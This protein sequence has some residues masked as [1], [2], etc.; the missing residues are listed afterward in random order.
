MIESKGLS[1]PN[2]F[3]EKDQAVPGHFD[4][5]PT[6]PPVKSKPKPRL[7]GLG[8][9]TIG[10]NFSKITQRAFSV[11]QAEHYTPLQDESD[12]RG[13]LPNRQKTRREGQG[14][15]LVG[16]RVMP[17]LPTS[18]RVNML[19]EEDS[20][21]FDASNGASLNRRGST[22]SDLDEDHHPFDD[23]QYVV[24]PPSVP[25]GPV[26]TPQI[27]R[28]EVDPTELRQTETNGPN[29]PP[30]N[31]L[32]V[33]ET[34][35]YR[36]PSFNLTD[37]AEPSALLSLPDRSFGRSYRSSV[38][39]TYES[40]ESEGVIHQAHHAAVLPASIVSP[41]TDLSLSPS[42]TTYQPVK[43][44]ESFFRR[45]TA[46]GI[47]GLLSG[48]TSSK[49]SSSRMSM[50]IRDPAPL[51][52][53]WPIQSRDEMAA[54]SPAESFTESPRQSDWENDLKPPR[55]LWQVHG[56]G[57]LVSSLISARSMRDMVIVQRETPNT[58][59]EAV[60]EQA[61]GS[62]LASSS[63]SESNIGEDSVLDEANISPQ[64]AVQPV[65][66]APRKLRSISHLQLDSP[67]I[68][69]SPQSAPSTRSEPPIP[70]SGS[71]ISAAI[72]SHRRPVKDMVKSINKRSSR[73]FDSVTL[74]ALSPLSQYSPS[75]SPPSSALGMEDKR[76]RTMYEAVRKSPLTVA[77]PDEGKRSNN[78]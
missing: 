56:K 14:I 63:G 41:S 15:R 8:M 73:V 20:R 44:T 76:P 52:T 22:G 47:S 71:P 6:T 33:D 4:E 72:V 69:S 64:A 31:D 36:I 9:G 16:P 67:S 45:M 42:S 54:I 3:V 12:E 35:Q 17:D 11:P 46:G 48:S 34:G 75:S 30:S 5:S 66:L 68:A 28:A 13:D 23:G 40:S 10:A 77:N 59:T 51:P 49:R 57:V 74:D 50:E 21:I 29:L 26:P 27:S 24:V 38:V 18:P 61:T 1:K 39:S 37:A 19:A 58:E 70:P 53:L 55:G 65:P 25:G 2:A 32:G 43:R 78:S 60:I 7:S 62:S